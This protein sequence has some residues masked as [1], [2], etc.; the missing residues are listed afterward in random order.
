MRQQV[1]MFE[2]LREA[3]SQALENFQSELN[4]DRI[5]EAADRLLRLMREELIELQKQSVELE[6]ELQAV[7]EEA[8][9][10][11]RATETCQR[12]EEMAKK[13]EDEETASIAREFAGR[14]LQRSE[15]LSDKAEVLMRELTE[16]QRNLD[17]MM[18]QFR[19][20]RLWPESMAATSGRTEARDRTQE[21]GGHLF[22]EM[23]RMAEKIDDRDA[24]SEATQELDQDGPS[25]ASPGPDPDAQLEALKRRMRNS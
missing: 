16:R 25:G 5:P 18:D 22:E 7:R 4:R 20:A 10:E 17:E 12:R 23:E 8:A 3:F 9:N 21:T 15:I 13:I 19:E 11:H 24:R 14:H 6:A 2:S 1:I